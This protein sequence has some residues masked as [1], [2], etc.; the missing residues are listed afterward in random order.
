MSKG[1][2]KKKGKHPNIVPPFRPS[3]FGWA[4]DDCDPLP[5]FHMSES[6]DPEAILFKAE[7][8][9]D[10]KE[11]RN[12]SCAP[13]LAFDFRRD[14]D[15]DKTSIIHGVFLRRKDSWLFAPTH[16]G[17]FA[18]L[19]PCSDL[20]PG[21]DS[22]LAFFKA[23][24]LVAILRGYIIDHHFMAIE[25]HSGGITR[26]SGKEFSEI[27]DTAI[28]TICNRIRYDADALS[29]DEIC[30]K[31]YL[32][33]QE[34]ELRLL[35]DIV[36][37]DL[38]M[39]QRD[40]LESGFSRLKFPFLCKDEKN[41]ILRAMSY[42]LNVNWKPRSIEMKPYSEIKEQL[43]RRFFGME[44]VKTRILEIAA[45]IRHSQSLP[46]WGI[47]LNGP[48]GVGKTSIAEEIA[49][50]LR[51]RLVFIDLSTNRDPE[52][53]AGS[54]RIYS[55]A[56][57][58]HI[59]EAIL[60]N[61]D[62]NC[63]M[64]LNE[65]DKASDWKNGGVP[66]DVF[67]SLVDKTGFK[68]N[69]LEASIETGN[70]FFVAT[71]NDVSMISQPLLDRFIRIDL[72]GYSVREKQMIFNDYVFPKMR[73]TNHLSETE[74][75]VTRNGVEFLCQYYAIEPG[76]RDL[77][78]YAER[79]IG[80]FLLQREKAGTETYTYGIDDISRLFGGTRA[81][82]R[83]IAPAP[84]QA[85]TIICHNGRASNVLIQ[86]ILTPGGGMLHIYG[87]TTEFQR[88]CCR[89]AYECARSLAE[90][91][92]SWFDVSL[93]IT[94]CLP[95]SVSNDLGCAVFMSIMSAVTSRM[96]PQDAVYIGG[97]DLLGNLYWGGDDLT[98]ILN[99]AEAGE[100]TAIFGPI[101][102]ADHTSESSS[103]SVRIVESFNA[104]LLFEAFAE[105]SV[106]A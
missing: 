63:V 14:V 101:G 81:K 75:Q 29:E 25:I 18:E 61:R 28:Q 92:F 8:E 24:D 84:G 44:S 102:L 41:H 12:V 38:S 26:E 30:T 71:C 19:F 72:Y 103:G 70:M 83:M 36:K 6:R 87:A 66:T 95:V 31:G 59:A 89:V 15:P 76:V 98:P 42:V 55:N 48:A 94:S 20:L 78:Q 13:L 60:D 51:R 35:Y 80:H 74:I 17:H 65:L 62:S 40:W 56:K 21:I 11:V 105:Q 43:D 32:L 3:P 82:S 39:T 16:D 91:D 47:L 73:E 22:L 93:Y 69:Y 57:P 54:S 77:E 53:L 68:E 106:D 90:E 64:L 79:L 46:K 104:A 96:L 97:C 5:G 33:G 100:E 50:V 45:Q 23:F 86:T 1:K 85:K 27:S 9:I 34:A 52:A 49:S 2:Q 7:R 67:L 88:D 10:Q 4:E 99:C 58:G 37:D